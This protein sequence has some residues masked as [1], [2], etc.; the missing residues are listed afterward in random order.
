[1]PGAI[2][3]NDVDVSHAERG[4]FL[5]FSELLFNMQRKR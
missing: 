3:A 2:F 5:F 4:Q 1:M